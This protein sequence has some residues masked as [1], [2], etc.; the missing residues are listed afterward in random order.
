MEVYGKRAG[1]V[2]EPC[3]PCQITGKCTQSDGYCKDCEENMCTKCFQNHATGKLCR[4][5]V[6][7]PLGQGI[8]DG[9][10]RERSNEKCK[11]HTSEYIKYYCPKHDMVTCGDCNVADH[12]G[13]KME[14]ISIVSKRFENS[15]EFKDIEKKD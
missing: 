11:T 2:T 14:F 1:T 3:E 9:K 4:N 15:S 13:C 7:S 8:L 12:H 10:D 5:H 6:M